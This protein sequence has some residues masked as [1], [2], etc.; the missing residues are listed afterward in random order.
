VRER[1]NHI[2]SSTELDVLL[3]EYAEYI[4]GPAG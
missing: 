4:V 1:V 2:T 3:A